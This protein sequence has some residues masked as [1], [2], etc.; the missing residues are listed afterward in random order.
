VAGTAS[1][2]A[3]PPESVARRY[4]GPLSAHNVR[5]ASVKAR[6]CCSAGSPSVIRSG[7]VR[8]GVRAQA[9][10]RGAR[11]DQGR[12][13]AHRSQLTCSASLLMSG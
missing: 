13:P 11:Q 4:Q 1:A 12:P 6:S 5:S 3:W 8:Y 7:A 10:G 2:T 9:W